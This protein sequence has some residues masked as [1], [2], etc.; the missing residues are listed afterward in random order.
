MKSDQQFLA[1]LSRSRQFV[2]QFAIAAEDAGVSVFLPPER[3]RPDASVRHEYADRGDLFILG[4]G[5]IKTR[6]NLSFTGRQDFPF[7]TVMFA[8]AYTVE[9]WEHPPLM[10]AIQSATGT[11]VAVV[12][13]WTR[14]WWKKERKFDKTVGKEIEV[15]VCPVEKVRFCDLAEVF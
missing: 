6:K 4:R 11:A 13:G 1:D 9:R 15:Y 2:N 7:P 10:I 8:E 12:Y 3:V 5:E 14:K